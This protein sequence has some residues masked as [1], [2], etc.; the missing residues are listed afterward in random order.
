MSL[1]I[2]K[3]AE[4]RVEKYLKKQ[5][6]KIIKRNFHSK[7]GEIDIIA[8]KGSLISFF[9]V[10]YSKDYDPIYRI[11]PTKLEKIIKTINYFFMLNQEDKDYQ[12]CA[13]LV[14]SNN[15]EILENIS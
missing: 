5:G 1:E 7:F 10:K 4:D 15:I 9:E 14:D 3:L 13:A 11:T 2:G 12:I 8:E 6:Y